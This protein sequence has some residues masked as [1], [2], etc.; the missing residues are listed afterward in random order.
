MFKFAGNDK[1]L[2]IIISIQYQQA[3]PKIKFVFIFVYEMKIYLFM[4]MEKIVLCENFKLQ[5][6][7]QI[8]NSNKLKMTEHIT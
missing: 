5:Q 8:K 3:K 7:A 6:T 4:S 2:T 1:I